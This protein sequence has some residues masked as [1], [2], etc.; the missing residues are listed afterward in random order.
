MSHL[1]HRTPDADRLDQDREAHTRMRFAFYGSAPKRS[2]SGRTAD[3]SRTQQLAAARQR[4]EPRGGRV[5]AEYFDTLTTVW[6]D[7]V[8]PLTQ[9][10]WGQRPQAHTLIK[11]LPD[12]AFDAV[13]IA[14]PG[15]R[16]FGTTPFWDVVELLHQYGK[17]LWICG[18]RGPID[19]GNQI[20]VLLMK[21]LFGVHTPG[22]ERGARY[23]SFDGITGTRHQRLSPP[24]AGH[25]Q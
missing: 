16:T 11:A 12:D 9:Q 8:P 4:I 1:E 20:D 3:L 10:P 19:P 14:D 2:K 21:I 25:D 15:T 13:V 23:R 6:S 22:S 24:N 7:N 17:R 5:V 18:I